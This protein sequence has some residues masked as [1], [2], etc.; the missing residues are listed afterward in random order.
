M[1]GSYSCGMLDSV[2]ALDV[3]ALA[4]REKECII[5]LLLEREVYDG[6]AG[7]K[8]LTFRP[9]GIRAFDATAV[10]VDAQTGGRA[11]G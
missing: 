8:S 6:A 4:P 10:G 5:R 11:H 7:T 1:L 3:P 2:W 9:S